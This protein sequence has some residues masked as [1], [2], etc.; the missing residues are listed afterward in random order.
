MSD[1]E[2]G[3]AWLLLLLPL[4]PVAL[5]GWWFSV[6][7]G[8]QRSRELSRGRSPSPPYAGAVLLA[9][10]AVAAVLAAAQPRWGTRI[11][12]IPREGADVVVVLDV[13]RSMEA[14]DVV[15]SR[16]EAAKTAVNA[17]FARLAGDRVGVV[18]FGGSARIR[19]PLTNDIGAAQQ[20]VSSLETGPVIVQAGSSASA[21]LAVAI[22]AFDPAQIGGKLLILVTDG[23]DLGP[24]PAAVASAV[25]AAG[26]DLL[27]V[28]VG[29]ADGSTVPVYDVTSRKF[30]DK[31][32]AN[33]KPIITRL[34]EPFLRT[35]A[36]ASGGRYLG[37]NLAA[38]P[39][40]VQGRLETIERARIQRESP[41]LPIERY[42]W[43]AAAALGLLILATVAE[44][45]PRLRS[46]RSAL[47]LVAALLLFP[48]CATRAWELNDQ[49][50]EAYRAGDFD[51]AAGLFFEAQAEQPDDPAIALNLASALHSAGRFG[52]A[53]QAARRALLSNDPKVRARAYAS[54]GHHR[55][56]DG[57]AKAALD[58]FKQA[59]LLDPADEASR[60][61]YEVL[62][63]L[64]EPEQEPGPGDQQPGDGDP[65]DAGPG[66]EPPP[67]GQPGSGDQPPSNAE[68][69]PG[70]PGE[71]EARL[72]DLDREI[73]RLLREAGENP[74][75]AEAIKI[76]DLIAERNRIAA[77]RE[78]L[79]GNSNPR[80]Y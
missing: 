30:I 4:A 17:T 49:A 27:V 21:G 69:R 22:D 72:S 45:L 34:D 16:L 28:G 78:A 23:N 10:A 15:P 68:P 56:A 9:L 51:G 79:T 77:M 57:D 50:R 6:R 42:Q 3:R 67:G 11:S 37:S 60:H 32:D 2:F 19:F 8:L 31:L 12:S 65:N 18:V 48:A 64:L 52:E 61:D 71:I 20:V 39:G 66:D 7:R 54:I 70:S 5:A 53:A 13:S 73:A 80:D 41:A 36:A 75:A 74:S 55:F 29:T 14:R 40:A 76:L 25:R 58:S 46:R 35:L 59:L 1:L 62:L 24:D 43:F 47:V 26:V 44:W 33:G 63:R 38:V